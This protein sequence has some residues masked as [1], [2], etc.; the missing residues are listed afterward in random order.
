MKI[1]YIYIYIV[2]KIYKICFT[3]MQTDFMPGKFFC[4]KT[5]KIFVWTGYKNTNNYNTNS[6]TEIKNV[7]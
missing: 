5:Q 7:S 2:I 6:N 1:L 3:K 4:L